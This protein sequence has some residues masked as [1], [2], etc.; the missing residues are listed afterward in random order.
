[1][2]ILRSLALLSSLFFCNASPAATLAILQKNGE[3]CSMSA[4]SESSVSHPKKIAQLPAEGFDFVDATGASGRL[5]ALRADGAVFTV[6]PD[7]KVEPFSVSGW[8]GRISRIMFHDG[9]LYGTDCKLD[10]RDDQQIRIL[11]QSGS[12][13]LDIQMMQPIAA[14]DFAISGQGNPVVLINPAR[15]DEPPVTWSYIFEPRYRGPL[16]GSIQYLNFSNHLPGV[17][18]R[19]H[20][21]KVYAVSEKQ[22]TGESI[23]QVILP[24][25]VEMPVRIATSDL[26][27][28]GVVDLEFAGENPVFLVKSDDDFELLAFKPSGDNRADLVFSAKPPVKDAVGM[29]MLD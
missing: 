23:L 26:L 24:D 7:G 14:K 20:G 10:Q 27:P 29:G 9:N 22:D 6:S 5:Y 3:V 1:M 2:K 12:P 25:Q 18:V 15:P 13:M 16:S 28:M 17:L 11:D 21:E 4:D 8:N 19:T